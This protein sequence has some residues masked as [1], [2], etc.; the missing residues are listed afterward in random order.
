MAGNSNSGRRGLTVQQCQ[1]TADRIVSLIKSGSPFN[2][3]VAAAGGISLSEANKW[4][5]TGR[6]LLREDPMKLSERDA[7][8]RKFAEDIDMQIGRLEATIVN[9][10]LKAGDHDWKALAWVIESRWPKRWG[11]KI[12][13]TVK[14]ELDTFLDKLESRLPEEIY[15]T[16][17]RAASEDEFEGETE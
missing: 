15:E 13:V 2:T 5:T 3:A 17:L 1:D 14:E 9:K 16:V 6:E 7:M 10:I 8:H 12:N 11:K 4:L